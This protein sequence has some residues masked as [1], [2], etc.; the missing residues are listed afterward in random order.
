MLLE[1][2]KN[3]EKNVKMMV[4]SSGIDEKELDITFNIIVNDI[5]YGFP[6]KI[7]ENKVIIN[8]PPLDTII[9]N[10][11]PGTYDSTLDITSSGKYFIQ[12][13]NEKI[14]VIEVPDVK[15]DK[16]SLAE[17]KLS[18]VISEL[19]EDDGEVK[20]VQVDEKIIDKPKDFNKIIE[21]SGD[22]SNV[23][24]KIIDSEKKKELGSLLNGLF[25]WYK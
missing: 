11:E 16:N 19:I 10:L 22:K 3:K 12:P 5:K 17:D 9:K 2:D 13:F 23:M 15:V 7:K 8:I 24:D 4:E 25:E 18:V 21:D 6:C 20:T 14:K 1:F